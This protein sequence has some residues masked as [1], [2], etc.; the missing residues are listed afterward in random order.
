[1]T[2]IELVRHSKAQSRDRWWGKPDRDR[3]LTEVGHAQSKALARQLAEGDPIVKLYSSPFARCLQTLEPL[4]G[5]LG[6]EITSEESLAE[7]RTLPVL[8]GGDAWVASAWLGGRAISLVNRLCREHPAERIVA[9]THGDVV[10]ALMAVLAGRDELDIPEV[11]LKKAA[12][13]TLAFDGTRCV[14]AV[15]EPPPDV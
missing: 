5:S 10:P 13:F 12:R 7:A 3:P 2:T 1:M 6:L 9:C 4:A 8:D 11:R 15:A 14:G